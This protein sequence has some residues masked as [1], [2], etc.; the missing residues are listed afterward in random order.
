VTLRVLSVFG[1]RP[2]AIKMAP[3]VRRLAAQRDLESQVCVTA[4]HREMLDPVLDLFEIQPEWDLGVMT[5]GQD[6]F[7]VT[8][9]VL[10]GM[11][12]VLA[13]SDPDIV[14]VHGDT[15]TCMAAAL[16]AFYRGIP[17][18]H[19]EAG[20]RSGNL[21][22]PFPEELHRVVADRVCELHFAPTEGARE[23]LLDEGF[24]PE[25]VFVTGNT[26]I[27]ALLTIRARVIGRTARDVGFP[28]ELGQRIEE[29]KG[30]IV[31]VTAHRRES[32]GDRFLGICAGIREASRRHPD[33]LFAFPLHLNP[34]VQRAAREELAD[35]PNVCLSAPL[36][37]PACVWLMTRCDLI[38]T[39]SGGIQ[40]EA[41]ALQ[42]P[43]LVM[44]DVT[45]RP[46]ALEAGSARLVGTE[47]GRIVEGLERVL[48]DP[49]VW[50][51][52]VEA[53]HPFG[54]GRASERIVAILRQ[55][56]AVARSRATA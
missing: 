54:D 35:L 31:L 28:A 32:F 38:L 29:W 30:R 25:R 15:T 21:R 44:R 53:R 37:Y 56:F 34:S 50:R 48:L 33:W 43:V 39:D 18:G 2:E 13:A 45:E 4:Q 36:E 27:D 9:R 51:R 19:V 8:S 14:L 40:E 22:L 5:P 1:T 23:N 6:L 17:V 16:A 12:G 7:D 47:P 11:R 20:L 26:V 41:P 49:E 42:K 46:E 55:S 10:L 24:A 3:V 52:M